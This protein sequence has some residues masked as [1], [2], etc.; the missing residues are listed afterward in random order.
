MSAGMHARV[1]TQQ[2]AAVEPR[3]EHL[4][5]QTIKELEYQQLQ[6]YRE[7][8]ASKKAAHSGY[9]ILLG[10]FDALEHQLKQEP[11]KGTRL[12]HILTVS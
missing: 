6:L 8:E 7:L 2:S 9:E 10:R 4:L 5:N 11:R 3:P 1:P 12:P